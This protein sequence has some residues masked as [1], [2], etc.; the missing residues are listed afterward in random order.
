MEFLDLTTAG[1]ASPLL[2][3]RPRWRVLPGTAF[4][5]RQPVMLGTA[6]AGVIAGLDFD[7]LDAAMAQ[8]LSQPVAPRRPGPVP[9][10]LLVQRF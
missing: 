5:L 3:F 7:A 1:G 8:L 6:E 4:G 9:L 10:V 2:Q